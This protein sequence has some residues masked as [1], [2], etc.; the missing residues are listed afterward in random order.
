[1]NTSQDSAESVE[2]AALEESLKKKPGR[3]KKKQPR[4][5]ATSWRHWLE[6]DEGVDTQ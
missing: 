1:M 2:R 5:G 6:S 3:P 4:H